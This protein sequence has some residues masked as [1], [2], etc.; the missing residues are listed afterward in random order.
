MISHRNEGG[1]I[2]CE[3]LRDGNR[4]REKIE[5]FITFY[6]KEVNMKP[7]KIV[8]NCTRS[9]IPLALPR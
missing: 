1:N 9:I 3:N 5:T 8:A 6:A 4:R 7:M 2:F